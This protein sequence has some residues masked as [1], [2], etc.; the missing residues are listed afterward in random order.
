MEPEKKQEP[1][2][3]LPDEEEEKR[4]AIKEHMDALTKTLS[5][6]NTNPVPTVLEHVPAAKPVFVLPDAAPQQV[7]AH[8]AVPETREDGRHCLQRADLVPRLPTVGCDVPAV[9]VLVL[10]ESHLSQMRRQC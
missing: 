10:T 9:A 5:G 6:I 4:R 2:S 8:G 3:L 1:S 7:G